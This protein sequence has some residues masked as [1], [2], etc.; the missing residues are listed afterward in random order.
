MQIVRT[1]SLSI[2]IS[3]CRRHPPTADRRMPHRSGY[4][5]IRAL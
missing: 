5:S 3:R 2:A 4:Q 1:R